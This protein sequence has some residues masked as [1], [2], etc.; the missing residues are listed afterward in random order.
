M[1]IIDPGSGVGEMGSEPRSTEGTPPI[2]PALI[3]ELF[4]AAVVIPEGG[5]EASAGN[6][7]NI[8][9]ALATS[10]AG[11]AFASGGGAFTSGGGVVAGPGCVLGGVVGDDG[12]TGDGED[13]LRSDASVLLVADAEVDWP[14]VVDC[15]ARP[16]DQVPDDPAPPRAMSPIGP[17][18]AEESLRKI[19]A[20][21]ELQ[22]GASLKLATRESRIAAIADME[23]GGSAS[24]S[25]G[26]RSDTGAPTS[27]DRRAAS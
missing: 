23:S 11:C 13:E 20:E 15:C 8:G 6:S 18:L 22:E 16:A 17:L 12:G 26:G 3:A 5:A 2:A 19:P 4:W 24:D 27:G 21:R 7:G 10:C 1:R 14:V 9:A 25:N